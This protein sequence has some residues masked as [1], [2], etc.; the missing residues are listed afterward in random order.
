MIRSVIIGLS[1]VFFALSCL[2]TF[3]ALKIP[4]KNTRYE[5]NQKGLKSKELPSESEDASGQYAK[6]Q[7]AD[8]ALVEE[9]R[10][11]IAG[12]EDEISNKN[13]ETQTKE[14]KDTEDLKHETVETSSV[15]NDKNVSQTI[16]AIKTVILFKI[17]RFVIA[18]SIE[19]REPVG[20]LNAV[21]SSTEKIY[22]FLEA[23]D[24]TEDTA[25]S[26]VWYYGGNKMATVELAVFKGPRWR[27]YSS[28]ELK[29]LKGDWKVELQDVNGIVLETVTFSVE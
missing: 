16:N 3:K 20:I 29:G 25:V 15:T 24:I 28:K 11:T 2:I 4:V 23:R 7:A 22:C 17:E 14:K 13:E 18:G 1:I 21:S 10:A 19:N 9:T 6:D 12:L 8:R 26:L 5:N 27:T